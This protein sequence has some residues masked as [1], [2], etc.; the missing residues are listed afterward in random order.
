MNYVIWKASK[1]RVLRMSSP[2]NVSLC[3]IE[4]GSRQKYANF[5]MYLKKVL[6]METCFNMLLKCAI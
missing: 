1:F 6:K 4:N 2:K 5:E 3:S